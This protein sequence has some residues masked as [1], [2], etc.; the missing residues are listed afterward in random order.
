MKRE[1]DT[2]QHQKWFNLVIHLGVQFHEM[3]EMAKNAPS[4]LGD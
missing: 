1:V 2:P 3:K 4:E